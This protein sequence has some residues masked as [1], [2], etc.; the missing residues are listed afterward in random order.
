MNLAFQ[1]ATPM[2][3][4][5]RILNRIYTVRLYKKLVLL[6]K[7]VELDGKQITNTYWNTHEISSVKWI[8]INDKI[9]QTKLTIV[10]VRE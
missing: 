8:L 3:H 1:Y 5:K 9:L 4:P 10:K 6:F 2:S 7:L